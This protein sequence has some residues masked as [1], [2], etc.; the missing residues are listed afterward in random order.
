[1]KPSEIRTFFIPMPAPSKATSQTPSQ[2]ALTV[3]IASFNSQETIEKCL[4]SLLVQRTS[5]RF[6]V[7][8]ADS[9]EDDTPTMVAEH[10]PQVRLV[11]LQGRH[12]AG[13]ARNAALAVAGGAVIALLDADCTV[14]SD[15][16][17]RVLAAH[18]D[19]P[20]L[21]VGGA[22]GNSADSTTIGWASY[23]CEFSRW[24]P[25]GLLRPMK[26]V[27]GASM[28]YKR[29]VFEQYGRFIE[30]TYCSDTEFH[31]RLAGNGEAIV[32]DPS[33]L[34]EHTSIKS[35]PRYLA[36]EFIHGRFFAGVRSRFS[37]FSQLRKAIYSLF[38]PLI[39]I[40]VL[41]RTVRNVLSCRTYRRFLWKALPGLA[42]GT[43]FWCAGEAAGYFEDMKPNIGL[44][45]L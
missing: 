7:I 16:V 4:S 44:C 11:R 25:C 32:F 1:M 10:F 8:V 22:I 17:E 35:L 15:W 29:Q 42:L 43:A 19:H 38:A 24:M 13:S 27:A 23:F 9:S 28:S 37:R 39:F 31:W 36:H 5:Q 18:Q 40:V 45:N 30:G 41:A 20:N 3:L 34:V 14:P 2:L 6:E 33:I 21:A 12:Y 26:D